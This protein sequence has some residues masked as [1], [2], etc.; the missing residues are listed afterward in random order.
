MGLIAFL[1]L[2]VHLF[3]MFCLTFLPPRSVHWNNHGKSHIWAWTWTQTGHSLCIRVPASLSMS[4]S[5]YVSISV[6]MSMFWKLFIGISMTKLTHERETKHGH[7]YGS[8]HVVSLSISIF[9]FIVSPSARLMYGEYWFNLSRLSMM[10][11]GSFASYTKTKSVESVVWCLLTRDG[12]VETG[13]GYLN[14]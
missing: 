4:M 5:I 13:N 11:I 2:F 10:V 14:R 8:G 7:G 6:S 1:T 12:D 9:I 3:I